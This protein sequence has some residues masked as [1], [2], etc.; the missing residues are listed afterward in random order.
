M[1]WINIMSIDYLRLGRGFV[2]S[3][4]NPYKPLKDESHM[5]FALVQENGILFCL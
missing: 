2:V 5:D 4:L 1:F 3:Y